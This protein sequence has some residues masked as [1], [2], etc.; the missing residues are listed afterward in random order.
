MT[1]EVSNLEARDSAPLRILF[2]HPEWF[3]PL[4]AELDRRGIPYEALDARTVTWDPATAPAGSVLFNR[5]S[6][7]AYLRGGTAAVFATADILA[8]AEV[9]GARVV[10]GSRAW[11]TEISKSA[12]LDLLRR[13]G[14]RAPAS[15][16]AHDPR[17]AVTVAE[18]LQFPVVIK[19]N[20]GG[21]GAGVTR[22]DTPEQLSDAANAGALDLGLTGVGLVQELFRAADGAIHRV[23]VVGGRVLYGIR[24]HAPEGEFNLCPADACQTSDGVSLARG[25][26]AVDAKDQ[27]LR[28]E[29]FSPSAEII[30]EVERI[31]A[32]AGIEVGGIEFVNDERTGERLYYDVNALSN[33][34]A[35]GPKVLGFD[36]FERLVDWLETEVL[37]TGTELVEAVG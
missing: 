10:N 21:S 20:V 12:Q 4:F 13:V 29:A 18:G 16:A 11:A 3:R 35:D 30:D 5:M 22:Y 7:S 15:R 33:F 6:P 24:V 2:E 37:P 27:G 23:E 28:V 26:C 19:P 1:H 14:V 31:A 36:P 17:V 34:V 25:A 8:R 9:S 32:A